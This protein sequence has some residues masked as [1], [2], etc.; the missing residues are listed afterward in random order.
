MVTPTDNRY[1][2]IVVGCGVAGLSAAVAAREGGAHVCLLERAPQDMRGGNTRW[3]GAYLRMKS[4]TEVSDDFEDHFAANAGEYMDPNLVAELSRDPQ[5]WSQV[6]RAYSFTDPSVVSTLAEQAAPTLAWIS[7]FGVKFIPLDVPFP[8]SVQP[9]IVP[10]GGGLALVDALAARF[11]AL[12]G[13]ITYE[14]AAQRLLLDDDGNIAGVEAIGAGSRRIKLHAPSVVIA[15][16]GFQGNAEMMSRYMGERWA[17]L[18]AM[19]LGCNFNKGEGIQMALDIGAAPCGDYSSFHASPMDPRS[20]RAGPSMYVYPYGILVN[21]EGRRFTDE[22]P[23]HTDETYEEVTRRISRQTKG[24]AYVILD[25][26]VADLPNLSVAIRTEQPAIEAPTIEALAGK[27]NLPAEILAQTVAQYNAA[28]GSGAFNPRD[29]D[30]LATAGLTPPKSNWSRPLDQGPFKA[31]PIISSIVFTFGG[32]KINPRGQVLNKQGDAIPGLYAA[33]EAQGL[34]YGSYTGA[35]SVL[36]GA[37]FGRIAGADAAARRG[38][39]AG[40]Q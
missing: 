30:G 38:E 9:R 10:S 6:L 20:N 36:K 14:T 35:T 11:E 3:T 27:L 7:G 26:K 13:S 19:S 23:G 31:Y 8:T 37:V 39:Q 28:C 34:Y 18:R 4:A 24:L 17:Y 21:L 32:L 29:L 22:A 15:S 12:D 16:G 33:G 1:D 2:V 40:R 5:S 25:A